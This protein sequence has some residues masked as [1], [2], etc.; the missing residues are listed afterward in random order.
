MV[1]MG[2]PVSFPPP[3][4]LPVVALLLVPLL[5]E[6]AVVGLDAVLLPLEPHAAS[7]SAATATTATS[8]GPG[9]RL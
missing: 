9:R 8:T 5:P 2:A 3:E 7:S 6:E 1:L 4:P